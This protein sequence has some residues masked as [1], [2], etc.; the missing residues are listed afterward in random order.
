[1]FCRSIIRQRPSAHIPWFRLRNSYMEKKLTEFEWAGKILLRRH[2]MTFDELKLY[3]I[4]VW[5]SRID[6]DEFMDDPL[7]NA[8][9]KKR[10]EYEKINNILSIV[11]HTDYDGSLVSDTHESGERVIRVDKTPLPFIEDK[12]HRITSIEDL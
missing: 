10:Q 3:A 8:I 11:H 1:M 12:V 2:V 6:E 7:V 9:R 5:N 4:N